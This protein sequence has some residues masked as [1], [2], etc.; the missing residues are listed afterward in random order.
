MKWNLETV[1]WNLEARKWKLEGAK[2]I[3]E[4]GKSRPGGH[5]PVPVPLVSGDLRAKSP[6]PR[7]DPSFKYIRSGPEGARGVLDVWTH[8]FYTH[9]SSLTFFA[10]CWVCVEGLYVSC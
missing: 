7:G 5:Y 9:P 2:R 3:S 4:S 1:K 10:H 6:D 8:P